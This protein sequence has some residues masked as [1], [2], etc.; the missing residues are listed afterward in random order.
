MT[1][2]IAPVPDPLTVA[3]TGAGFVVP[4]HAAGWRQVGATVVGIAS[5]TR[6]RAEEQARAHGIP[7]VFDALEEML[8]AT[9][10]TVLDI[11]SP[12][13][14]HLAA[15]EAA[16]A[17]GI[18]VICQKPVAPG[19]GEA[20][21]I[22]SA[23]R[24]AGIRCMVH[25]NFRFRPWYREIRR[26]LDAGTIGRPFYARSDGRMG[27]TVPTAAHP[28][29]PWSLARQ[30]FM[31]SAPRLLILES[32]IHQIDVCRY[33]FGDP[34][35]VFARA[36]RVG[37]RTAGED[38]ASLSMDFAGVIAMVER[39]YGS[40]G[41]PDPP[42]A[43]E[44]LTVEGDR[45][46]LFLGRDGRIRAEIDHPGERRTLIP[47]LDLTDAYPRSYAD[48]IGHFADALRAG[49]AFETDID[50]NLKTLDAT[51]A[52]YRSWETGE[53]VRLPTI[54]LEAQP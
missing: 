15:V 45:G 37:D 48:T 25:E 11:C 35:S 20:L 30:P 32:V 39:S 9:R 47:D 24:Q 14:A 34:T 44:L 40:R 27:G 12:P 53:A 54:A 23:A 17:R 50:D 52:A 16:A 28:D 22:R 2:A 46:A 41:Y 6:A 42:M 43:S 5:R 38:L 3:M 18:H 49:T 8:D 29:T 51:L 21:A 4:L 7:A 36:C 13:E 10:P 1:T 33:L 19:L 26:L 31:A